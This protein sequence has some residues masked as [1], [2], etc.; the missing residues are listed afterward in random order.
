M[1]DQVAEG[2]GV[3]HQMRISGKTAE[4][5]RE[6]GPRKISAVQIYSDTDYD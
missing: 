6:L 4:R 2:K 3:E 1:G 5:D